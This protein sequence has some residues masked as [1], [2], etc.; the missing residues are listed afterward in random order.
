[1]SLLQN[2]KKEIEN[3]NFLYI[4]ENK[5]NKNSKFHVYYIEEVKIFLKNFM[6]LIQNKYFIFYI[7]SLF[8]FLS[9]PFLSFSKTLVFEPKLRLVRSKN[10]SFW[11]GT[12]LFF[13]KKQMFWFKNVSWS[14]NLCWFKKTQV[15]LKRN[16]KNQLQFLK[17]KE[18]E[19]N[20][21]C[22]TAF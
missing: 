21:L 2:R 18:K 11:K 14:K 7:I 1:M 6:S 4:L 3:L 9:V 19:R 16:E 20:Q 22:S 8:P 12:V 5:I 13:P 10:F 17:R 15:F